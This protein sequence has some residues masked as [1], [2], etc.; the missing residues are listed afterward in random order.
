MRTVPSPSYRRG[1]SAVVALVAVLAF[2][3]VGVAWAAPAAE[4]VPVAELQRTFAGTCNTCGGSDDSESSS[5]SRVGSSYW[6]ETR[7]TLNST[8]IGPAELVA[9]ISNRSSSTMEHQVR[10]TEREVR[11]VEFSGGWANY[12]TASIGGEIDESTQRTYTMRIAPWHRGKVY[13]QQRTQRYT[14]YGTRYQDYSDGSRRAVESD[15]GPYR[16]GFTHVSFVEYAL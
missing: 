13:T 9:M 4:A 15:S 3:F 12:F 2:A 7:R 16:H 1:R 5:P 10:L 14:V 11:R 8:H 6:V